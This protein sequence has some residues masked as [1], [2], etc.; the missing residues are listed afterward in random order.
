MTR[1]VNHKID[2]FITMYVI[3]IHPFL[4]TNID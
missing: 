3:L 2:F 4:Y 1:I